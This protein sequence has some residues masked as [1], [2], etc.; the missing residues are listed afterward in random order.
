MRSIRSAAARRSGLLLAV[1]AGVPALGEERALVLRPETQ[2]GSPRAA[3]RAGQTGGCEQ[4][5]HDETFEIA[6]GFLPTQSAAE[7]VQAFEI[8]GSNEGLLF[9]DDVCV[10]LTRNQS[11]GTARGQFVVFDDADGVPGDL[12][13]ARDFE[14]ELP[15]FPGTQLCSGA[16]SFPLLGRDRLHAG[17]SWDPATVNLFVPTDKT[18]GTPAQQISVRSSA[19]GVEDLGVWGSASIIDPDARASGIGITTYLSMPQWGPT[20]LI[21]P[22]VDLRGLVAGEVATGSVL[23]GAAI[24]RHP[25]TGVRSLYSFSVSLAGNPPVAAWRDVTPPGG[26]ERLFSLSKDLLPLPGETHSWWFAYL[27]GANNDLWAARFS[28]PVG[29]TGAPT[30][31]HELIVEGPYNEVDA[32]NYGDGRCVLGLHSVRR[33][34]ELWCSGAPPPAAASRNGSFVLAKSFG[35]GRARGAADGATRSTLKEL[36]LLPTGPR[37]LAMLAAIAPA[38]TNF[39]TFDLD[40]VLVDGEPV[41]VAANQQVGDIPLE[42]DIVSVLRGPSGA[43]YGAEAATGAVNVVLRSKSDGGLHGQVYDHETEE[44]SGP[45]HELGEAQGPFPLEAVP[46][47]QGGLALMEPSGGPCLAGNRGRFV[48]REVFFDPP[49]EAK[50]SLA[51]SI[52]T[53]SHLLACG[54]FE[55]ATPRPDRRDRTGNGRLDAEDELHP[56]HLFAAGNVEISAGNLKA[57]L[58]YQPLRIPR[59]CAEWKGAHCLQDHRLRVAV[60]WRTPDDDAGVG[61][62]IFLTPSSGLFYFSRLDN[63]EMIVKSLDACDSPFNSLWFFSGFLTNFELSTQVFD[64]RSGEVRFYVNPLH[65]PAPSVLD[66]SALKTCLAPAA[67]GGGFDGGDPAAPASA[68]TEAP[69]SSG[70]LPDWARRALAIR[71]AQ[72]GEPSPRAGNCSPG[73]TT[74]CLN[75]GRFQ[76]ETEWRTKGGS[77]G[78]GQA[79]ELTEDT[80]AFWFFGEEN[81]EILVKVLDGC[82]TA[83]ESFWVFAAGLTNVEVR[84][85]VTDTETGMVEVYDNPR[86]RPYPPIQDT[87][88]F[89][90]CP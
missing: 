50:I 74:L 21:I 87:A 47:G 56:I 7:I 20:T 83:F 57:S 35:D 73:P 58:V 62:T 81:V 16:F 43:L 86:D 19:T 25:Q 63:V 82:A 34:H 42:T 78:N 3:P 28:F 4:E 66:T 30:V 64:S 45:E 18:P 33:D 1:L 49:T 90:T 76:V 29:A 27:N 68:L 69:V 5:A 38:P 51:A 39:S 15:A 14:A 72:R 44:L 41:E 84:L 31:S 61:S 37:N 32:A 65:R 85:T 9:L 70:D 17:V 24:V 80:G 22:D 26:A 12:L 46:Y 77:A 40:L 67:G 88:A 55:L 75:A 36:E 71:G 52:E 48:F 54:L 89:A 11:A 13:V 79:I 23:A 59:P 2:A 53:P 8:Q 10:R 6:I 60:D